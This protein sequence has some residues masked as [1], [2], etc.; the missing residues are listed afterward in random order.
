M[1]L[2]FF[3]KIN[4]FKENEDVLLDRLIILLLIYKLCQYN[5]SDQPKSFKIAMKKKKKKV[6]K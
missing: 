3:L 2:N 5:V 1:N 4:N 6:V